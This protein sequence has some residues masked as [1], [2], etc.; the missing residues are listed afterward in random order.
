MDEE[1]LELF[2]AEE[3]ERSQG[4]GLKPD[5]GPEVE[6]PQDE[7][8]P[9]R[10]EPLRVELLKDCRG[11]A[12]CVHGVAA[13]GLAEDSVVG[14]LWERLT[15]R[16]AVAL[17]GANEALFGGDEAFEAAC[18]VAVKL[19]YGDSVKNITVSVP[20]EVYR[21]ARIQAAERG[22]SVSSLVTEYLHSL[23]KRRSEFSRLEAQQR[24]VQEE[25]GSFSARDRLSR[26]ETHERAAS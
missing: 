7:W 10:V 24:R 21:D 18:H 2:K 15:D 26:D 4:E 8:R 23:S 12:D 14:E 1:Q 13:H 5:V 19:C 17:G 11:K 3:V 16:G 25:I 6:E 22:T 20:D 9:L